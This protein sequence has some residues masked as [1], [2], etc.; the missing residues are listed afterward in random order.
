MR[1]GGCCEHITWLMQA[2]SCSQVSLNRHS[3]QGDV[4]IQE[5]SVKIKGP[6]KCFACEPWSI[7]V[8]MQGLNRY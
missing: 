3:H 6:V 5:A 1:S 7:L 8:K 2:V 4:G